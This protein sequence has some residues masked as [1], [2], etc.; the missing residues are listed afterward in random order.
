MP[1]RR[2][3]TLSPI[4][5]ITPRKIHPP[6]AKRKRAQIFWQTGAAERESRFEISLGNI[7]AD[8]LAQRVHYF[9]SIDIEA[10]TER[11]YFVGGYQVTAGL[12]RDAAQGVERGAGLLWHWGNDSKLFL[13]ASSPTAS[14][15]INFQSKPP[16]RT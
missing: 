12:A 4:A 8:V 10:A 1:S 9:L 7:Q 11:A 6:G 14:N 2:R 16:T 5:S 15:V 3:Q 13:D